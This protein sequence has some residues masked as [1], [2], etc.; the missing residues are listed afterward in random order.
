MHLLYKRCQ[1]EV[2]KN[3]VSFDFNQVLQ[4]MFEKNKVC[5]KRFSSLQELLV[6]KLETLMLRLLVWN[7]LVGLSIN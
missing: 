1:L 7:S 6:F 3:K 5:L 4:A 2:N